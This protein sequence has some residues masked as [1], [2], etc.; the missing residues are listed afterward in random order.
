[1]IDHTG[2]AVSDFEASKTFY[3]A[4]MAALGGSMMMQVPKEFTGGKNVVGYGRDHPC[5]WLNDGTEPGPGRHTAFAAETRAEV[6]AFHAAA[7]ANGGRDNGAPG[8]R[9]HYH[10]SY[11][12]AFVF[13]PDG[14]N[15]EA[16][17]HK[18]EQL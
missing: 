9:P 2:I 12:A 17:C 14:N 3:D 18:P 6:D 16:V 7:L 1:M 11:Y 8:L 13:D 4:I 15:I 5:F 10:A